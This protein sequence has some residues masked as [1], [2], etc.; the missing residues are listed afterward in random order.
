[1]IPEEVFFCV[2]SLGKAGYE[3]YIVGGCTRDFL[4]GKSPADW[5]LTT[6]AAPEQTQKVFNDLG[7]K[8]FYENA[9]G[10]VGVAFPK[11]DGSFEIIEVTT[12]RSEMAYSDGRHPDK[13]TW[14]KTIAEDLK[15]RDFTVNAIAISLKNRS[16]Y[17]IL[18][19][20]DGK[21]D[22]KMKII[23]AV[24]NPR[25][26]FNEDALRMMRAIRLSTTLDV[27]WT[28]EKETEEAIRENSRL[29]EKISKERLRDEI[30]KII[31]SPNAANGIESLRKN[32]LL[33][34]IIPE[35]EEGYEVG[36]NKHHIYSCYRHNLESLNYAAQK[37]FNFHVK[38]AALLH[39]IGKPATKRGD[40]P[41]ATFYNH[42]IVGAK[43]TEKILNRL[44]FPKKDVMKITALV[45]Y[46]LFYYNV[47]E[48]GEASVRRL[49][50]NIGL[51][52][53]ENLLE[54]R[55]ADRIG[56]GCPK[57]EPYKLRHLKYM[58]EKVSKD[59]VSAKMLKIN[60]KDIMDLLKIDPSPRIGQLLDVLLEEVLKDPENNNKQYLTKRLMEL[61]DL[62]E[63]ELISIAK[64]AKE[65]K[66]KVI[67]KEDK[68]AKDKYKVK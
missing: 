32:G 59:P 27:D 28:I 67:D 48:V 66:I 19:M 10:T 6:N 18:D 41:S 46:H 56:S 8:T 39:D 42:E 58:I 57:A 16:E 43:M 11:D 29:L 63:K 4:R 65:E 13:V 60:G 22:L 68:T 64:K 62:N 31:N 9:F 37:G 34:Y 54:L 21:K 40:G 25:E 3:A 7:V 51:E 15:R 12:Y 20:F 35:L 1:M 36:Q 45:R 5:D 14:S 24:G 49:I 38:L 52:N 17:D 44:K 33:K 30:I 55:M 53:V 26:R 23:R 47:D 2:E 50:K 61:N